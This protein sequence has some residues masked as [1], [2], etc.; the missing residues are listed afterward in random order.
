MVNRK[1]L[2]VNKYIRTIICENIS[3]LQNRVFAIDARMGTKLPFCVLIR[4]DV[5]VS[6][7]SKDG[8]V[9]DAV[10]ISVYIV[11]KGYDEGI[12]IANDLRNLLD[13]TRYKTEEVYIPSIE[14]S[15]A[16]EMYADSPSPA[17]IQQLKF[18][19]KIQ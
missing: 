19:V 14:F 7:I 8:L 18:N 15:G 5:S 13:R 10:S 6:T 1:T 4:D 16:S 12:K 17:F 9:E 2:L 3:A 11:S